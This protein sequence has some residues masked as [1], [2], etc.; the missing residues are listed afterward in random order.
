MLRQQTRYSASGTAPAA[1][2]RWRKWG[3]FAHVKLCL[4]LPAALCWAGVSTSTKQ[5]WPAQ[6]WLVRH[7]ESAG[8]VARDAAEA[9][10]VASIDIG[11]RDMDVPLSP[12]GEKQARALGHWFGALPLSQRPSVVL[13]SPYLRAA[14][15]GELVI[16]TAELRSRGGLLELVDE[17]LREKEF[18]ILNRLTKAGILATLPRE[19]ELRARIGKFYYRPPGGES[20]CDVIL[21]LRSV[22]DT[23]QLQYP[24][25]SVLVVAHQVVVL[26]MRYLLERMTEQQILS[27]DAQADVANCSIT[28]YRFEQDQTGRGHMLLRAYNQVAPLRQAGEKVTDKPDVPGAPR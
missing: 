26:C 5:S 19:A 1:P 27:I 4:A 14:R 25:E 16:E 3:V 18:G 7:G 11:E 15:T 12:L 23:I 17:R 2:C 6:L 10:G 9:A 20:W 22:L 24:G 8:N 13:M 28:C 21:R